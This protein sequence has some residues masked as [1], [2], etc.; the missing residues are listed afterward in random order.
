MIVDLRNFR[1]IIPDNE[2]QY[3][4]LLKGVILSV[5][6]NASVIINRGVREMHF[7]ISPSEPKYSQMLLHDILSLHTLLKIRL[8]LSKSIRLTSTIS[9]SMPL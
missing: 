3:L 2:Q 6:G 5:D 9:F 4:T 1:A 8:S 7:R